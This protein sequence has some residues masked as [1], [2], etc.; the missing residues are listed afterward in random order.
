MP[1][2]QRQKI[3]PPTNNDLKSLND[4]ASV[5]QYAFEDLFETAHIHSVRTTAPTDNDGSVG[6][7]MLVELSGV[8]YIYA[9]LPTLGWKRVALS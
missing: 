4:F 5:V 6:D 9:K 8:G 7:I 1:Q 3:S 2:D